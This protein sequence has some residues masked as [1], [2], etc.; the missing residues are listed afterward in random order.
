MRGLRLATLRA[1]R[2][3]DAGVSPTTETAVSAVVLIVVTAAV[4]VHA[5]RLGRRPTRGLGS[6][7]RQPFRLSAN[8]SDPATLMAVVITV[9]SAAAMAALILR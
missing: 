1:D 9:M 7:R 8:R 2:F 4:L 5:F 3:Y 6:T